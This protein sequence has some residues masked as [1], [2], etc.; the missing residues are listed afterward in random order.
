MNKKKIGIHAT[1]FIGW[2]GGIDFLKLIMR[3][4]LATGKY[5]V[6]LLIPDNSPRPGKI[7]RLLHSLGLKSKPLAADDKRTHFSEFIPEI[8]IE[9]YRGIPGLNTAIKKHQV[10]LLIP[11]LDVLPDE[12]NAPWIGYLYDFQH[13]YLPQFFQQEEIQRR[14]QYFKKML[15]AAQK[16]IVNSRAVKS[17]AD[18]FYPG[19]GSEI[20]S[21]PFTPV[22]NRKLLRD[23]YD[24]LKTRYG[25]PEKYFIISNQF[26]LHKS[27]LTAFRALKILS[28][29]TPG[30]IALVCTGNTEDS[31]DA[32][33]FASL[34]EEIRRMGM[35]QRVYFLG[36]I[37][38]QD[39]I[40]ILLQAIALIQPTLFEGGPGGGATYDAIA[41]GKQAIISDIDI[42]KEIS[43]P[44]VTFF[45]VGNEKDLAG[46]MLQVLQQY[47]HECYVVNDE[48][49]AAKSAA[50]VKL[51]GQALDNVIETVIGVPAVI[52][53]KR[54]TP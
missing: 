44:L 22:Y 18:K 6:I 7:N 1:G 36:Y 12:V 47:Q 45:Q 3:G 9:V 5:D 35:E 33:Y 46:K 49:L 11:C 16:I 31:R 30:N 14:D 38:K 42:N 51:L 48:Q 23:N 37:S 13:K 43:N 20:V 39:Q 26:W 4:I 25:L 8:K 28:E 24:E 15:D 40:G 10:A 54:Q 50:R 32:A 21:L 17:D 34:K 52:K 53:N 29:N 27:H 41:F 2:G 19:H